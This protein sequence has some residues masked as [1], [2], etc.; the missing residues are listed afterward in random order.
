MQMSELSGKWKVVRFFLECDFFR[1]TPQ[2][3][4]I[5]DRAN[6]QFYFDLQREDSVKSLEVICP[7][8]QID[9]LRQDDNEWF[10]AA[11]ITRLVNLGSI[12]FFFENILS[13]SI[14]RE[15]ECT[16]QTQF[17]SLMYKI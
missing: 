3:I 4:I 17:V 16:D 11:D 5:A 10:L 2:L 1:E 9:S 15:I 12:A 13:S 8:K 14:G 6:E 7:K